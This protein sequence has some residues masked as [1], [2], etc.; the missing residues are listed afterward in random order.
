MINCRIFILNSNQIQSL[1]TE[2]E[3]QKLTKG[4][5]SCYSHTLQGFKL[6]DLNL[7]RTEIILNALKHTELH[8]FVHFLTLKHTLNTLKHTLN[9][10]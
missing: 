7:T 10:N 4:E 1:R 6:Q 5:V 9:H 8:C 3:Q 2:Q